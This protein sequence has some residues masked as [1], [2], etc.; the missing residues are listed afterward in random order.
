MIYPDFEYWELYNKVTFFGDLKLAVVNP[1]VT[2]LDIRADLWSDWVRWAGYP[3]SERYFL[4]MRAV[5]LDVIPDGQTGDSYFM[6]N[7]WKLVVDITKVRV[8]GILWSDDFETAFYSESLVPVYPARV[9]ALVNTVN[10][11]E[12]VV[13]GEVIPANVIADAVSTSLVP[14]FGAIPTDVH[15]EMS[16]APNQAQLASALL[17]N[18]LASQISIDGISADFIFIL[19]TLKNRR[20]IVKSGLVWSLVVYDDDEVSPILIKILKDLNGNN[21]TDLK[22]GA[23]SE[24]LASSV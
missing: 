4:A 6:K 5:G 7:G 9:S 10:V 18:G 3:G 14:Y 21:I 12:N 24:E 23:L 8:T 16:T 17:A 11:I 1:D 22:A 15:T 13:T 19:K 2:A 20:E